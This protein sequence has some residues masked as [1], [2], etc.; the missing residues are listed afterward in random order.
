MFSFISW[1]IPSFPT[2]LTLGAIPLHGI[3]QG[4][5]GACGIL[6]LRNLLKVYLFVDAQSASDAETDHRKKN[7][8][9]DGLTEKIQFWILTVI[10]SFVGSRVASL[11]VLEFSLRAISAR[12]TGASD[13]ISDPLLLLLVQCQ[14]SLSCALSCSLNFLHE[15]APQGWLC[16]ILAVG[17]SWFLASQCSELW[18][19]VK[20]MY[21][22]HST[23]RYCGLCIGLLTTGSSILT[24]LCSVLILIFGVSG[25]AA[26]SNINQHFL[27]T[28]EAL[29]FWTPLTICYTL[30]VVYMNEHRRQQ[31]DQQVLLNTVVVRLGGLF[32]L[33]M[34]V[35]R[36]S[37]VIHVLICFIG[38]AAC[39]F[40]S[41]D[42][43]EAISQQVTH[44]PKCP[45]NRPGNQIGQKKRGKND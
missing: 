10:L 18:H 32:V 27:S 42:I 35:G 19:H 11:V 29:R 43:L 37:D 21:P 4:L 13:P 7:R 20:T 30:L 33:L 39:L 34:T 40:P 5:V 16:L 15:E 8:S 24:W 1:F 17:L 26:I 3:L 41:Q 45:L 2:W 12:I 22:I 31:P 14:F 28:T 23:Q 25:I 6:V 36:W 38:E 9:N 44:V